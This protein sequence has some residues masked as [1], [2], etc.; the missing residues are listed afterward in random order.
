M[1]K[2]SKFQNIIK[3]SSKKK[4]KK[5]NISA[6]EIAENL[7]LKIKD[8]QWGTYF[9]KRYSYNLNLPEVLSGIYYLDKKLNNLNIKKSDLI[10]LDLETTS[11]S[12]G[13]GNYP[14]LIGLGF[15]RNN[16][17]ILEQYL[18]TDV[19]S[20]ESILMELKKI[21]ENKIVVSYNGK[22]F[23][24]PLIE[25]RFT[26]NRIDMSI[27]KPSMD[28]LYVMRRLFKYEL[29]S[30]N[31]QNIS[32]YLGINRNKLEDV[33][34]Y[35]IPQIFSEYVHFGRYERLK[36][37]LYHNE[38]DVFALAKMLQYVE[39]DIY[40][41]K[42]FHNK[43]ILAGALQYELK[44]KNYN[45]IE[46]IK[47]KKINKEKNINYILLKILYRYYK[48]RKLWEKAERILKWSLDIFSNNLYFLKELTK[49]YYLRLKDYKKAVKIAKKGYL[50]AS[51]F[52]LNKQK[53]YFKKILNRYK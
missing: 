28:L 48:K 33:E 45:L 9:Y 30:F 14:F 38:R 24:I 49:V 4:N 26:I 19:D 15:F 20:E 10:F 18:Y 44:T 16:D 51:K 29:D 47:Y 13:A 35:E 31:L 1:K 36:P 11:L 3:R 12:I 39:I 34:G 50:V 53:G 43:H 41:D 7:N 42:K 5:K 46:E 17:F 37:V 23:D 6:D 40:N 8:N 25:N 21:I 52:G 27:K 22:C 2:L 32:R